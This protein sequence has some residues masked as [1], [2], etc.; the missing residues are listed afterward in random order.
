VQGQFVHREASGDASRLPLAVIEVA[1]VTDNGVMAVD[2]AVWLHQLTAAERAEL[3]RGGGELPDPRPDVLIVGGGIAGVATAA[4]CHEAG[5]GSVL[6]IEAGRLGSG[7]T[8]GAAGLLTPE[9]HEWS[10]P[11]PFVDLARAS[12]A[13]WGQLQETW[14][15]GVGLVALDWIG[16]SPDPGDFALHQAPAIEWLDTSQV[17]ELIPGLALPMAGALVRRQARVNPL[18]ALARLAAG[19]P[20][21]ATG[22]AATAVTV[23]AGRVVSVAT[24]AG[25]VQPGAVVFATGLPP[26]L[27]G[28]ELDVPSERVKG[29]LLVTEPTSLRL[30]GTV[31]PVATQLED[32]RLLVGGTFDVGDESPRVQPEVID[33]ILEGLYTTLPELRGLRAAYQWCCFRPRHPDGQPVI[34]RVPGLGNA[35]LTSGHYRTGILLAPVTAQAIASWIGA[36]EPPA[37][38]LAWSGGRFAARRFSGR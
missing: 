12:L 37:E 23:R 29:H 34:D 26:L 10:D 17:A 19:L 35:W 21:V 15:G 14:P 7:A 5:L 30:P 22:V 1:V 11:A 3:A 36:G 28:L 4:A 25:D 24:T 20:A 9:I 33:S 6:L 32:G 8:G 27:D 2:T 38:A 31:A 16:L 13:R 18:R